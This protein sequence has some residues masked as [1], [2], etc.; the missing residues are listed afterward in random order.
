MGRVMAVT[1]VSYFA[2]LWERIEVRAQ[3]GMILS[4]FEPP[5]PLPKGRGNFPSYLNAIVDGELEEPWPKF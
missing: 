2:A 1:E 5:S 3:R 4:R